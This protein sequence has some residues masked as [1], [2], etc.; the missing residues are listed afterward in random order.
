MGRPS[1]YT[2]EIAN[3]IC[4]RIS[5][6]ESVRKICLDE[7]M[8]AMSSVFKW[9]AENK[10]FSEQYA[11]ARESQA[12]AYADEMDDIAK[13]DSIPVDRARLIIDTRKW[14]ASKLKPKKYG[15][16]LDLTSM[17]KELPTPILGVVKPDQTNQA[18]YIIVKWVSE[19]AGLY[20]RGR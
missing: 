6:G 16:K 10:S 2:D 14:T 9:L 1:S 13:N 18:W 20:K 19:N 11:Y 17:G 12:D 15:D 5:L 7:H 8:P 4:E 3:E